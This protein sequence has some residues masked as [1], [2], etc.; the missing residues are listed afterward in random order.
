MKQYWAVYPSTQWMKEYPHL[1]SV[2]Y[3]KHKR[4]AYESADDTGGFVVMFY[5]E[6]S[7]ASEY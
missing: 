3:W 7:K 6:N 2:L 4:H 5:G 1:P